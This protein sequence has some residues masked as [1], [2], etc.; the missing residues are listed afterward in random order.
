M[1]LLFQPWRSSKTCY[2]MILRWK[3]HRRRVWD[4][5]VAQK[6]QAAFRRVHHLTLLAWGRMSPRTLQTLWHASSRIAWHLM[7]LSWHTP[8]HVAWSGVVGI[9]LRCQTRREE[10]NSR[11][12]QVS[13]SQCINWKVLQCFSPKT[14]DARKLD[15]ISKS[16]V[17]YPRLKSQN[18]NVISHIHHLQRL[19]VLDRADE[20]VLYH[21]ILA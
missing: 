5:L 2:M 19:D 1:F 12:T 8:H 9:A 7:H 17:G 16:W 11:L 13:H 20:S 15:G 6:G 21:H 18:E 4:R 3:H 14:N 10:A